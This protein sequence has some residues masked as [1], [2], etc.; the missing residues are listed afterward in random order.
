M[1]ITET[2]TQ[3][4]YEKLEEDCVNFLDYETLPDGSTQTIIKEKYIVS[5]KEM[6]DYLGMPNWVIDWTLDLVEDEKKREYIDT[7]TEY[8]V[9]K[10]T[11]MST[12]SEVL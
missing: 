7:D 10:N 8:G 6:C 4:Y 3:K 5:V 12:D 9:V 1:T 2:I 11:P